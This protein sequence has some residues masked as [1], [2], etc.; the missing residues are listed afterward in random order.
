[1]TQQQID[2]E[3]KYTAQNYQP[4]PIVLA[5]GRGAWLWDTDGRKYLDLM[6]AYSA[7]SHG[8]SHPRLVRALKRQA[9]RLAIVSRAYHSDKLGPFL[10]KLCAVSGMDKALPMN[11]GA[12]A[13]E[14]A[15]KAARRWGHTIK[16]IPQGQ[17]EIIVAEDN[18]H[19][20]TTTI[21]SMSSNEDYKAGFGP[22][23]PG[24]RI[25]PFGDAGAM[26]AAITPNTAAILIEPIQGEAGVILPPDGYL[27][28]LR[29]IC[30]RHNV[31][32][33]FDE[34]QSGLGRTGRMFAFEHEGIKPDGLIVGKALGGGLLP[35]SAFLATAEVMSVFN[36]GS[37]GS[38]FGGNPL[39]AAVGL[40]ALTILEE[41]NLIQNSATLGEF[42]MQR[43]RRIS[44]PAIKLVRGK[45]LWVA[46]EIEAAYFPA[47]KVAEELMKEGILTKDTHATVL[48][49]APPLM[50]TKPELEWAAQK[51]EEVLHRLLVNANQ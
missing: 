11:T 24:F 10:A 37:H 20:R 42:F 2:F 5:K 45:G 29:E 31:L 9:R 21:I 17:A 38:T 14:T 44:S 7:V 16:N 51:I 33:I 22:L 40:E 13:V 15:I 4:L 19:G 23:T 18:F 43:L 46:L 39:A 49:L 8:H 25:V 47:R 50:V 36:P 27:K 32:L 12:E 1:M 48:R 28:A 3:V 26:E 34:V 41:E 6:S 35:V 30:D